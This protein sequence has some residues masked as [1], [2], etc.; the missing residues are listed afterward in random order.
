MNNISACQWAFPSLD[1]LPTELWFHLVLLNL[2]CIFL[3]NSPKCESK[4]LRALYMSCM[5][6]YFLFLQY[7]IL[8]YLSHNNFIRDVFSVQWLSVTFDL[9]YYKRKL[10]HFCAYDQYQE[11]QCWHRAASITR[12]W[13]IAVELLCFYAMQDY[14]FHYIFYYLFQSYQM[15]PAMEHLP[16]YC[17]NI[18]HSN[19]SRCVEEIPVFY[20]FVTFYNYILLSGPIK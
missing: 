6:Y 4:N 10:M 13:N 11:S 5:E 18:S 14:A 16:F 12:Y 1:E 9:Q 20:L 19:G 15:S 7:V 3:R 17:K 8:V 2:C